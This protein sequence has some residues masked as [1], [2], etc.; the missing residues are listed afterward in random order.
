MAMGWVFWSLG[1]DA[2]I[3]YLSQKYCFIVTNGMAM[4]WEFYNFWSLS[5]DTPIY[6]LLLSH[7][8]HPPSVGRGEGRG[9]NLLPN[10]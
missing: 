5:I 3:C 7:S 9:V 8:V 10:F 6:Y 1:I 4:G 2:P